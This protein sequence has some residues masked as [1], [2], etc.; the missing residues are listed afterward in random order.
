[1]Y[2]TVSENLPVGHW[3][4]ENFYT[5][6]SLKNFRTQTISPSLSESLL[7]WSL[8]GCLFSCRLLRYSRSLRRG[9]R[10]HSGACGRRAPAPAKRMRRPASN[11][12]C[13]ASQAAETRAS[14]LLASNRCVR[15]TSSV[16]FYCIIESFLLH[17]VPY[18][19]L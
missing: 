12:T 5:S 16:N 3:L 4:V 10:S 18:S 19:L 7:D 9:L 14:E 13:P 15:A 17:R 1:M 2:C 8:W 6:N 11:S